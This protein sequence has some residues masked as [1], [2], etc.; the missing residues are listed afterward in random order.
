MELVI[1]AAASFFS[2]ALVIMANYSA[3]NTDSR[4][5]GYPDIV[6]CTVPDSLY[7]IAAR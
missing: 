7:F 6:R 3:L 2:R 4:P 5:G 1:A